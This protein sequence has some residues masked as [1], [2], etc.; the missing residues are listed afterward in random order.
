MSHPMFA[1]LAAVFISIALAAVESRSPRVRPYVAARV[2]MGC[3]LAV[4]AGGWL[5]RLIRG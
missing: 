4:L 1:L 5:M 2:F 3:A